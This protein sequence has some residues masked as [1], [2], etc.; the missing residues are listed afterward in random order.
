MYSQL[1]KWNIY[2]MKGAMTISRATVN[3]QVIIPAPLRKKFNIN[4]GTRVAIIEG[5]GNVIIIKP[6][7]DDPIEASRGV[8]KGKTSMIKA[9]IKDRREKATRG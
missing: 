1:I 6:L 4:K 5:E 2:L 9:L 7:P 3:G 8:L